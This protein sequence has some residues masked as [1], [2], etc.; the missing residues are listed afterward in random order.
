MEE[1][2]KNKKSITKIVIIVLDVIFMI[3]FMSWMAV[4]LVDFFRTRKSL[5][6]KFCV[7][8]VII[9]HEDYTTYMCRGVGYKVYR[10]EFP[11]STFVE[12]G[13]F[14]KKERTDFN[15]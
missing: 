12:F 13:P 8:N 6:P 4:I 10:Y 1:N 9:E 3:I 15:S 14:W 7:E 2:K 5:E 11:G